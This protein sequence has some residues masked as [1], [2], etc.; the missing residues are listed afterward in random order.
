MQPAARGGFLRA[1]TLSR[2]LVGDGTLRP[3]RHDH[4]ELEPLTI[5]LDEYFAAVLD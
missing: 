5:D 3:D 1:R 2:E 4:V